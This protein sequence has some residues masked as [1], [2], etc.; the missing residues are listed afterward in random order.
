MAGVGVT[1][2]AAAAVLLMAVCGG[3]TTSPRP[4]PSSG[5]DGATVVPAATT[6][7]ETVPDEGKLP[8]TAADRHRGL[9]DGP[10]TLRAELEGAIANR[11]VAYGANRARRVTVVETTLFAALERLGGSTADQAD[12]P[13]YVIQAEADVTV[14]GGPPRREPV[15]GTVLQLVVERDTRQL[16]VED[17]NVGSGGLS[18][19]GDVGLLATDFDVNE[20]AGMVPE[21][22]RADGHVDSSGEVAAALSLDVPLTGPIEAQLR[23]LRDSQFGISNAPPLEGTVSI[24]GSLLDV[25]RGTVNRYADETDVVEAIEDATPPYVR[26]L[27]DGR[28]VLIVTVANTPAAGRLFSEIVGCS[29]LEWGH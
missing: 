10:P 29:E 27:R 5:T 12:G 2:I 8:T 18:P 13:V 22:W 9:F 3:E 15:V 21:S 11:L 1:T 19:L 26:V 14:D 4:P 17:V 20:T 6:E 25:T 23:C 16:L 28:P 24:E 7:P